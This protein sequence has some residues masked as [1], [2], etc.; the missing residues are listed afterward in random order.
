MVK[1]K[2]PPRSGSV[3]LRC[4]YQVNKNI[5]EMTQLKRQV[6]TN[7]NRFLN[8]AFNVNLDGSVTTTVFGKPRKFS[9]FWSPQIPKRDKNNINGDLYGVF[10]LLLILMQKYLS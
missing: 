2:L 6:E 3:A 4:V 7:P 5:N 9:A 8:T 10:N 1:S